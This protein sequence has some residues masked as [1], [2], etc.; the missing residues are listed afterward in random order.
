MYTKHQLAAMRRKPG[1]G[2]GIFSA[3]LGHRVLYGPRPYFL[4][5]SRQEVTHSHLM[6]S[7]GRGCTV[8][9]SRRSSSIDPH[10]NIS[11]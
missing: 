5:P 10:Q 4:T 7:A 9:S 6:S 3:C 2:P 8:V 11:K 1:V